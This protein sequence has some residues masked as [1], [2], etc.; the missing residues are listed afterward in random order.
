MS[1][2]PIKSFGALHQNSAL[3]AANFRF[4]AV[5][6]IPYLVPSIFFHDRLVRSNRLVKS[7]KMKQNVAKTG[8]ADQSSENRE[9]P[10]GVRP[11]TGGRW[12]WPIT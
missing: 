4:V 12:C 3:L 11:E 7:N 2:V 1:E 10:V 6:Y 8:W 9:V 5:L